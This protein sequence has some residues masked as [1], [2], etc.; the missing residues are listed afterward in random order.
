MSQ[1]EQKPKVDRRQ[2]TFNAMLTAAAGLSG[3]LT[4]AILF[5]A[6]LLGLWIDKTFDTRPMFT[7]LLLVGSVPVTLFVML[8]VVRT[9]TS[10][11]KPAE[12]ES[13]PE[14]A[15]RAGN[16]NNGN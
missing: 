1:P 11:I 8:K 3:C 9:T 14:E 6:L 4:V 13:I 10:R 2:Y 7:I 5:A 12:K 15:D 16:G